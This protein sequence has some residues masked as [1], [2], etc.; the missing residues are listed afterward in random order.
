MVK[1]KT[2]I[3]SVLIA[4]GAMLIFVVIRERVNSV[5][6]DNLRERNSEISEKYKEEKVKAIDSLK[7]LQTEELSKLSDEVQSLRDYNQTLTNKLRNYGKNPSFDDY[8]FIERAN[9]V[10]S[11]RYQSGE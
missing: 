6:I 1:V 4:I 8:D 11:Y 2:L 5:V 10:A 9:N 7:S 3:I